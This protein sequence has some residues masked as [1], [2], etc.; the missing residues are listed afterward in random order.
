[1]RFDGLM[2]YEGHTLMIDDPQTKR[3]AIVDAIGRLQAARGEVESVGLA[4][5]IASCGG[6]GSYQ[7]TADLEGITEIQ[8]GG[9]IFGCQYYTMACHVEGHQPALTVRATVVSRPSPRR[10]I[11]DIGQKSIS[12]HKTQ[13]V[14]PDYPDCKVVGLSAEHATVETPRDEILPIGE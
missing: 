10:A 8:A 12:A 11:L 13:P 5:R 7:Y 2:G 3:A 1:L 6:T 4:C 9:G 14:L